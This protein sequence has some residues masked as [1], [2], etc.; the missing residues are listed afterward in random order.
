M[1]YSNS[2]NFESIQINNENI[3]QDFINNSVVFK[4]TAVINQNTENHSS[5]CNHISNLAET[6]IQNCNICN[7][8]CSETSDIIGCVRDVHMVT[9]H[10]D[11]LNK[12]SAHMYNPLLYTCSTYVRLAYLYEC[13]NRNYNKQRDEMFVFWWRKLGDINWYKWFTVYPYKDLET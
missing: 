12:L 7:Q 5:F 11:Y 9:S 10:E 4:I 13:L 2:R 8:S 3:I 6:C 1:N